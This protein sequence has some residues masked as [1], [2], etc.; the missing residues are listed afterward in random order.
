MKNKL[1]T[2]SDVTLIN[3]KYF[4]EE[5]G[6]LSVIEK[7]DL[8]FKFNRIFNVKANEGDIR[9]NHAHKKCK[10]FMLCLN[11]SIELT[12]DDGFSKKKFTLKQ[13]NEGVYV[14][15]GIWATQK[16]LVKDSLLMVLCDLDYDEDDYL[17]NYDNFIKFIG[18]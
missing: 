5:R 3:V 16:Y 15:S 13:A 17:R 4:P 12:C 10:Q 7:G 14:P 9:G 2:V 1:S 8:P 18:S 11:G 6:D